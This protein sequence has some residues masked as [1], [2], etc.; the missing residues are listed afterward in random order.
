V[1]VCVGAGED[2]CQMLMTVLAVLWQMAVCVD[3]NV[4]IYTYVMT[5]A[6]YCKLV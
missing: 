3:Q 6:Q 2:Q 5:L 1:C 4:F